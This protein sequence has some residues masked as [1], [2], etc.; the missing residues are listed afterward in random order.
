MGFSERADRP[1]KADM[2]NMPCRGPCAGG[3]HM[4]IQKKHT[5][6]NARIF[7]LGTLG[8][9]G[10]AVGRPTGR[11]RDRNVVVGRVALP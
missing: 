8:T 6:Y 11:R 3:V 2:N 5:I 9:A 4:A 7:D 1:G 10:A